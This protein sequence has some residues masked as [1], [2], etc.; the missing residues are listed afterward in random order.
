MRP[1]RARRVV[2]A[3][4]LASVA[5]GGCS[6]ADD[7]LANVNPFAQR[8][9]PVTGERRAVIGPDQ[10]TA[11]PPGPVRPLA[12][13]PPVTLA[14]WQN[15]GG[16]ANNAAPHVSLQRDASSQTWRVPGRGGGRSEAS[17]LVVGGR[18]VLFEPSRVSAFAVATGA[19]AWTASLGGAETA[20]V[21][22][23]IAS[24]GQRVFA[25]NALRRLVALD[26]A[27]GRELW[28]QVLPEPARSAPTVAGGRVVL[29]SATGTIFSFSTTDGREQWR[30]TGAA[31]AHGLRSGASPALAGALVVTGFGTGE[32]V[33]LDAQRGTVRWSRMV[34]RS[35]GAT[36]VPILTEG[37]GRAVVDRGVI[38]VGGIAGR[39][40]ALREMDGEIVWERDIA[41]ASAPVVSGDAVFIVATDG[42]VVGL[43][44]ASGTPRWTASLPRA[45]EGRVAWTGPTLAGN[46]L[47]V[48]SSA[49]DLVTLD[50]RDGRVLA[51]RD[52]GEPLSIAPVAAAGRL[53]LATARGGLLALD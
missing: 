10:A 17:P 2:V 7:Y 50:P 35:G 25:A 44:R 23:G 4:A 51:R 33:A 24:D 29:V 11:P 53:F 3:L 41:S 42:R 9:A 37:A 14:E 26:V 12:P 36:T 38:Y 49:G 52:I 32:V 27:T 22:G 5:L 13:A 28:A 15:P 45:G 6:T 40:L 47:H 46:A 16:P 31:E 43:E 39:V 48:V 8:E 18:V 20:V 1:R 19:P 30:Q 21:G 34:Q